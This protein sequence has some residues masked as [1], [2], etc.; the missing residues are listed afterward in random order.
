M[1]LVELARCILQRMCLA[2]R[3][4]FNIGPRHD[5][6]QEL[7]SPVSK[8]PESD[9]HPL[10]STH[11]PSNNLRPCFRSCSNTPIMQLLA[12]NKNGGNQGVK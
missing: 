3:N 6:V 2:A 10:P 9:H 5:Y 7:H 1:T 12:L 8:A 4:E 11:C